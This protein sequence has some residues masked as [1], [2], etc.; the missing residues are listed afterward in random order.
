MGR[1]L[2]GMA[3]LVGALFCKP[4]GHGF[5]S[6][7]GHRLQ[8]QSPVGACMRGNQLMFFSL[9][10]SHPLSVKINKHVFG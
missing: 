6:W 7:S 5:D 8:V 1:A 3:Q 2:T 10:L 9:S 4:K